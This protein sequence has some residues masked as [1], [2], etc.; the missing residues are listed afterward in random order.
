MIAVTVASVPLIAE[1]LA[2]TNFQ[3]E[4]TAHPSEADV[5]LKTRLTVQSATQS[6]ATLDVALAASKIIVAAPAPVLV[7]PFA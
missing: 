3:V 6:V 2:R 4:S 5:V 1:I 7:V